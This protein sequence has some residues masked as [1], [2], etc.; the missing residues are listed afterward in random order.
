MRR[1]TRAAHQSESGVRGANRACGARQPRGLSSRRQAVQA[2]HVRGG[3]GD[4]GLHTADGNVD[5][6]VAGKQ[7]LDGYT[8]R[9]CLH[10][11]KHLCPPIPFR[12]SLSLE[13]T[14][15]FRSLN[16]DRYECTSCLK[17]SF[18]RESVSSDRCA[19]PVAQGPRRVY[20]WVCI[21]RKTGTLLVDTG[22]CGSK[23]DEVGL[24]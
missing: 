4:P 15:P 11:S 17:S 10:F 23:L 21:G 16:V 9:K 8:Y 18:G 6:K 20:V 1:A 14:D 24:I 12:C 22:R 7:A 5:T 2:S 13:A 19:V 3:A